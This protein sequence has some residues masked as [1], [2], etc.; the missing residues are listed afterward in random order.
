MRNGKNGGGLKTV[1]DPIYLQ[2]REP[3]M[4]ASEPIGLDVY[5]GNGTVCCHP[6]H[7][8]GRLFLAD[9]RQFGLNSIQV[10]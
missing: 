2:V 9:R 8:V 1:A 6:R 3:G 7:K 10:V 5:V 4:N